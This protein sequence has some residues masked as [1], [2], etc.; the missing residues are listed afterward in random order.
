MSLPPLRIMADRDHPRHRG[1]PNGQSSSRLRP[2][3]SGSQ[4]TPHARQ[5]PP[6][7]LTVRFF[8]AWAAAS[9]SPG[10]RPDT[11][12]IFHWRHLAARA[13]RPFRPADTALSPT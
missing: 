13:N 12:I 9:V 8:A 11:R 4:E 6:S 1:E 2:T 3:Q 10:C 5:D 7:T